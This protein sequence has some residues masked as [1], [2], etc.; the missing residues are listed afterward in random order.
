[1]FTGTESG[2]DRFL[3]MSKEQDMLS[4]DEGGDHGEEMTSNISNFFATST[5][6]STLY[7][8]MYNLV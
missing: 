4:V 1:M 5:N 6:V 7:Y 2:I 8:V 3:E